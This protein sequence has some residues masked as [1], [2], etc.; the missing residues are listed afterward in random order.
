MLLG[1]FRV[2]DH[3]A[4]DFLNTTVMAGGVLVDRLQT[5][6][7]VL[8]WLEAMDFH[9]PRVVATTASD[10]LRKARRLRE[11]LRAATLTTKAG[12]TVHWKYWNG[13]LAKSPSHAE[14]TVYGS[15]AET[16][17]M[18]RDETPEEIL[19]P[20]LESAVGLLT[21][22]EFDLIR[23]CE[24]PACVLWFYDRTKSHRRRWCSMS[25]CGNRNKIAAFRQRRSLCGVRTVRLTHGT[26]CM[27]LLAF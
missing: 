21:T 15:R 23:R 20:L 19:G 13:M 3:P 14:V 8:R 12:V 27:D 25:L 6:T 26:G 24:D 22:G 17:R 16:K 7:D 10:L 9:P 18:W 5:D 4:L 2:G 11:T 1:A